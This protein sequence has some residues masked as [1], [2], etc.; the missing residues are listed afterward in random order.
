VVVFV[1]GQLKLADFGLLTEANSQV[2][3]LG[4]GGKG[5]WRN[6]LRTRDLAL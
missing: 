2:S 5:T 3:G 1:D 6:R 4:F